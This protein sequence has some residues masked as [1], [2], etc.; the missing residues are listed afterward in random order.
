MRC[1]DMQLRVRDRPPDRH[2]I[3]QRLSGNELVDRA[4]DNRFG[5][6]VF[7]EDVRPR[8][9]SQPPVDQGSI[10]RL[11]ADDERTRAASEVGRG[12]RVAERTQVRRRR[13]HEAEIIVLSKRLLQ[14]VE[15][16]AL[17]H[18]V[19]SASRDERRQHAGHRQ[20]E[21]HRRVE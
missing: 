15:T 3:G 12:E 4:A 6:T 2:G 14:P 7:V 10:E 8:R 5:G 13:L 18:D 17:A 1:H 20:V 19:N 16:A 11:A 9:V 21:R